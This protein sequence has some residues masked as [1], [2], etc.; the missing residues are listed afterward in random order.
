MKRDLE[1]ARKYDRGDMARSGLEPF[2]GGF[3]PRTREP[4]R[5]WRHDQLVAGFDGSRRELL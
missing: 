3:G 5:P 1:A 2:P 4:T